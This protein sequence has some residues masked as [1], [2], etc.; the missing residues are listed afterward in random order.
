MM[1]TTILRRLLACSRANSAVE[2]A[3]TAPIVIVLGIGA[4]DYGRAYVEKVRVTGA[5]RA[6][7]QLA[8]YQASTW[9]ATASMERS[10]L[11]EYAGG[12]LTDSEAAALPVSAAA[13]NFCACTNGPTATCGGTCADG[14]VPGRFVRVTLTG[15]TSLTLP[16]PWASGGSTPIRG[17]ALVRV[18]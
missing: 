17:E 5:A 10:A 2:F 6:G 18:R 4:F 9:T 16:Y 7:A 1:L 12:T 3:L 11:E 14:S 15:S 13:D 8:L